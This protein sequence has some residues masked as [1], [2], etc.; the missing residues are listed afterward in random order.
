MHKSYADLKRV[1]KEFKIGYHVYLRENPRK[2]SL[3]L[4]SCAKLAP[5][6]CG[7]FEVLDKIGPIACRLAMPANIIAHNVSLC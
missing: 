4:G 1:H 5:R 3:N 7:T 6:Y 2:S